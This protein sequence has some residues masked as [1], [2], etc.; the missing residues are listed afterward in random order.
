MRWRSRPARPG[1][2]VVS[3][4]LIQHARKSIRTGG[5]GAASHDCSK[6]KRDPHGAARTVD[7]KME[8][9]ITRNTRIRATRPGS[10]PDP[11][12]CFALSAVPLYRGGHTR[13]RCRRPRTFE[14]QTRPSS[15]GHGGGLLIVISFCYGLVWIRKV[16]YG[17][18]RVRRSRRRHVISVRAP[19]G[20]RMSRTRNSRRLAK[21][22]GAA[23]TC[24]I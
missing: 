19:G 1:H 9:L 6:V 23:S 4:V 13:R 11:F 16:R 2:A 24:A 17:V 15:H 18:V 22:R 8:P 5:G 10:C 7:G 3:I 14:G 21:W 20:Q 12:A